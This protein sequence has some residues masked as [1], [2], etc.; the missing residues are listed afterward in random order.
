VLGHFPLPESPIRIEGF[1]STLYRRYDERF[2]I[3]APDLDKVT[4]RLEWSAD[5]PIFVAGG[6]ADT[7]SLGYDPRFA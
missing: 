3:S 1:F 5:S 2:V 6:I 4:R 7:T